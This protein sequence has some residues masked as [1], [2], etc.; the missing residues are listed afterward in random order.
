MLSR[1]LRVIRVVS[2]IAIL[3]VAANRQV[4]GA[5]SATESES[6]CVSGGTDSCMESVSPV[7]VNP[8]SHCTVKDAC[9]TCHS[10]TGTCWS[11]T[12]YVEIPVG[13]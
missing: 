2:V 8:N 12:N 13:Q 7:L 6:K 4:V 3:V 10:S 9:A 1:L 5:L 11:K